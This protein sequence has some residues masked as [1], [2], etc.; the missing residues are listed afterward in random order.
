MFQVLYEDKDGIPRIW[1]LDPNWTFIIIGGV[2]LVAVVLDQVVHLLQGRRRI[3]MAGALVEAAARE[4][5][6]L[7]P[8]GGDPPA[9][10]GPGG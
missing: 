9:A 2:I 8:A 5:A 1:R 7:A 4:G 3:R 6:E 10:S